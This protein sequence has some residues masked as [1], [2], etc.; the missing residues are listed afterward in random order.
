MPLSNIFKSHRLYVYTAHTQ[1]DLIIR[2]LSDYFS[3]IK[4]YSRKDCRE[5]SILKFITVSRQDLP[6]LE[7]RKNCIRLEEFVT[8]RQKILSKFFT[9]EKI[10]TEFPEIGRPYYS[11]T[12][13]NEPFYSKYGRYKTNI[14]SLPIIDVLRKK[15]E[16][17]NWYIQEDLR[18]FTLSEKEKELLQ[19]KTYI[20]DHKDY[21]IR[22]ILCKT[23]GINKKLGITL[24]KP[25]LKEQYYD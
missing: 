10:R 14:S 16:E 25:L 11:K 5:Y 23:L 13:F 4:Y 20:M 15:Y 6:L 12:Y 22:K 7:G 3:S 18:E 21:Y 2:D 1:K 17:N 19:K 9:A 8:K 24:P